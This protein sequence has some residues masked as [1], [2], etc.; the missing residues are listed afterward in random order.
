MENED[1]FSL[2]LEDLR[3]SFPIPPQVEAEAQVNTLLHEKIAKVVTRLRESWSSDLDSFHL[4]VGQE[5]PQSR[6]SVHITNAT[7]LSCRNV[8]VLLKVS[9]L[10]LLQYKC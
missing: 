3:V 7:V 6:A 9:Q 1:L 2:F 8:L 4:Y 10:C 5:L